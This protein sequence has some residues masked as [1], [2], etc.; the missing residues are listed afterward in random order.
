MDSNQ[1][2]ILITLSTCIQEIG[3]KHYL[4]HHIYIYHATQFNNNSS[5]IQSSKTE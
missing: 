2:N 4:I 5:I 3:A 1:Q